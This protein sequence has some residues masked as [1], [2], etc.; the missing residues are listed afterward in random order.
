MPD[1]KKLSDEMSEN[2]TPHLISLFTGDGHFE[3]YGLLGDGDACQI[4]EQL[5][6]D[7]GGE[8]IERVMDKILNHGA[9]EWPSEISEK[10]SS[11]V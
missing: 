2:G 11:E 8:V 4:I 6:K 7:H 10:P 5:V 1:L 3:Y 9:G